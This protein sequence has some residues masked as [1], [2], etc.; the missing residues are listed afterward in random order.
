MTTNQIWSFL[1]GFCFFSAVNILKEIK[2]YL[3]KDLQFRMLWSHSRKLKMFSVTFDFLCTYIKEVFFMYIYYNC[4][5]HGSVHLFI[6]AISS[7]SDKE[8]KDPQFLSTAI[9]TGGC[10]CFFVKFCLQSFRG[11]L[12]NNYWW[13]LLLFC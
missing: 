4:N 13:L 1:A 12:C 8:Q 9:T 5:A 6:I 7:H 2:V 3:N 10:F 11:F